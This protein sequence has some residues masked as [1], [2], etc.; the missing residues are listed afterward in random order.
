[1]AKSRGYSTYRG[2]SPM[3]TFLK[4]VILLLTSVL[5]LAILALFFLQKYIVYSTDGIR[6]ELPFFS[7]RPPAETTPAVPIDPE[8]TQ[9]VIIV[10]PEIIKPK[11]LR[12]VSLP[13]EALYDGTALDKITRAEGNA[14][15]FDMKADSG[16]L[17]FV[18]EQEPAIR[19]KVSSGD[20][21]INAAIRALNA[22]DIY[23]VAR[24]SCFK[25]NDLSNADY[26]LSVTTNSGY[27]WT[28]PDGT[29]WISPTDER[30]RQYV[31]NICA[32][33]AELGFDEILL[34]NSGYPPEG[35][36]NYIRK[37]NAYDKASF[38]EVIDG[39]YA[40]VAAALEGSGAKLSILT[41]PATVEDGQ[42]ELTGQALESMAR[43]A[44][45][46]WLDAPSDAAV[47]TL[48]AKGILEE[49]IVRAAKG[50]EDTSSSWAILEDP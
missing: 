42:S 6:L 2:R 25:D 9:P 30:V 17:G 47:Q 33:L 41:D 14:A 21:A 23:T 34:V 45:R 50:P 22:T 49:D 35:N 11:W 32:E 19:A 46:I 37:G 26:S 28:D 20:A 13:R 44:G 31:T 12:A 4:I 24:V 5:I 18:S 38:G 15:I 8:G 48:K 36:L 40:Q 16:S 39:F 43:H 3:R 10:T 27:R 29:R 7:G 1:M